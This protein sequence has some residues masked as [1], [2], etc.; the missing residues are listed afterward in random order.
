MSRAEM[1]NLW[2]GCHKK[3]EG[4]QNCYV[5]R[6]DEQYGIDASH[7]RKT[8]AF[9]LPLRRNRQGL[10]T[11]P[12]G[13]LLYTCFT[14]DFFLEEAD[15]WR[16][17]AWEMMVKRSDLAFFIVTKRPERIAQC[18]PPDWGEG[19][20]NVTICCTMEN[21]RRADE[22][23]P[24]LRS[25]PL[26]HKA[27]ICEPLLGAIDF[28]KGLGSWCEK[29]IVGGESGKNARLCDYTW[30]LQIREQCQDF[31]VA[32]RFKQTGAYFRKS[33]RFYR[34]ERRH[35]HEQARLAGIDWDPCLEPEG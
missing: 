11:V 33:G 35:Q 31:G 14:S 2:H 8:A 17:D 6:R 23:L 1:W 26:R 29:V 5:Y 10:Y 30:V 18:L 34:I 21:Q 32:F 28:R 7:V 16:R 12:S 19:A 4:C 13:T 20:D 15:A 27:I 9:S 25:L 3:S 22:R 24:L